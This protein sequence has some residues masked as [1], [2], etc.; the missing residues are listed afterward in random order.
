MI[1]EIFNDGNNF[2]LCFRYFQDIF[3]G[4]EL[5]ALFAILD[6]LSVTMLPVEHL[7]DF[8]LSQ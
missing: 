6:A 7:K 5:P 2:L 1:S 3:I 4:G 8:L